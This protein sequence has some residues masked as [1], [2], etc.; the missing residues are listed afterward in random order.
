[1]GPFIVIFVVAIVGIFASMGGVSGGAYAA[2][3]I[4]FSII[5][6]ALTGDIVW[7]FILIVPALLAAA[8]MDKK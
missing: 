8:I 3:V 2:F 4:F 7:F 1:M 6:S 5:L